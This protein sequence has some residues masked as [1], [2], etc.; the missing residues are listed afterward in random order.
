MP[1]P[2]PPA[3]RAPGEPDARTQRRLNA[4]SAARA[5]R[6]L[7][8]PT[9]PTLGQRLHALR[10]RVGAY[11]HRNLTPPTPAQES[12]TLAIHALRRYLHRTPISRATHIAFGAIVAISF[13][14]ILAPL[15]I[16]LLILVWVISLRVRRGNAA[17]ATRPRP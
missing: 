3:P 17:R 8:A 16:P 14:F 6:R 15:L 5:R 7:T 2:P 12:A 13:C 11:I 4:A 10:E 9:A 1:S